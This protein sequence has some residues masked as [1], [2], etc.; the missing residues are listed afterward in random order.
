MSKEKIS[1][2]LTD[3]TAKAVSPLA[4][5]FKDQYDSYESGQWAIGDWLNTFIPTKSEWQENP[6]S[7]VRVTD[8]KAFNLVLDLLTKAGIKTSEEGLKHYR[9]TASCFGKTHRVKGVSFSAYKAL[10][11]VCTLNNGAH[12]GDVVKWLKKC[13]EDPDVGAVTVKMAENKAKSIKGILEP[14][15]GKGGKVETTPK[16]LPKGPVSEPAVMAE[17]PKDVVQ[18]THV[19]VLEMVAKD[20]KKNPAKFAKDSERI[21]KAISMIEDTL[22]FATTDSNPK[23]LV[24]NN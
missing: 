2:F 23:E 19:E 3:I 11:S 10:T 5:I 21:F 12:K 9:N 24:K 18:K 15:T 17:T 22:T 8:T 16:E 20:I 1:K 13:L 7:K 14:S 4:T 6:S